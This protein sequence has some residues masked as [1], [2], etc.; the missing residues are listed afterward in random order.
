MNSSRGRSCAQRSRSSSV[1][2]RSSGPI[3]PRSARD[4][5]PRALAQLERRL[6]VAR[7]ALAERQVAH[8]AA[9]S[10]RLASRRRGSPRA[11]ADARAGRA[12]P[13]RA[14]R[15]ARPSSRRRAAPGAPCPASCQVVGA[16]RE[17]GREAA[18]PHA[19][20]RGDRL[21]LAH[22]HEHAERAVAERLRLLAGERGGDV[23]RPR[24]GPGGSRAGRS[25]GRAP[26]AA[27]P[28]R[29]PP[30]RRRSPRR[31]SWPVT[32][33]VASVSMRRPGRAAGRARFTTPGV[34]T[35]AVQHTSAGRDALAG[36]QRG[37]PVVHAS[38]ASCRCG[39]PCRGARSSRA[40]NSARLSGISG[41]IRSLRLDQDPA[42]ADDAAARVAVDHVAHV[43]LQLGECPRRPRSRRRRRRRSGTRAAA[44]SSGIDSAIS[45]FSS[46]RLRSAIGV[47]EVLEAERVLGEAGHRQH[48]RDRAER[49]DQ[50]VVVE[51]L[52][53]P[54]ERAHVDLV[55]RR[56]RARSRGRAEVRP[57]E[58]LAQRHHHVARLERAGRG[59]RQQ[60]RVE[61]EVHV[62]RRA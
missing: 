22:V 24:A 3:S 52:V 25:A 21:V 62:A 42:R 44:S 2:P 59:A 34:R 36:R 43:V 57:L 26:C 27:W 58:L 18:Q 38:R 53:A 46:A 33:I 12:R 40:A 47:G 13:R 48:A 14:R 10:R 55:A 28:G 32:R 50:L 5:I 7:A 39:S 45:R 41:M 54:V 51:R 9:A 29:A 30:R 6:E 37:A 19:E 20:H 23:A 4:V 31:S 61:Q 16:R 11:P 17:P 15:P 35:P 1:R 56:V 8:R 60:R 49:D